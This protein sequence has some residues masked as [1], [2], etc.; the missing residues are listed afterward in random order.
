M[1]TAAEYDVK[2]SSLQAVCQTTI[3]AEGLLSRKL[4]RTFTIV[5]D[6]YLGLSP[7]QVETECQAQG[8]L[9]S[10]SAAHPL[11]PYL[12]V[13]TVKTDRKSPLFYE[14]EVDYEL[15]GYDEEGGGPLSAPAVINFFTLTTQ[16]GIDIDADG[17]PIATK[18]LSG[19]VGQEEEAWLEPI[20]GVTRP[21]SDLAVRIKQGIAAFN[22]IAF[23]A[24]ENH[25][26]SDT[27]LGFPPGTA[28]IH[29][30][31]A[32][33]RKPGSEFY[34][35]LAVEIHFR[36]PFWDTPTEKAWYT[37]VLCQ[38]HKYWNPLAGGGSN[39]K[40]ERALTDPFDEDSPWSTT[41]VFL[42]KDTGQRLPDG[43]PAQWNLFRVFEEVA[44][45]TMELRV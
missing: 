24:Y 32:D 27:F 14:T 25:V 29:S 41:P 39:G 26:N 5:V 16:S 9:P 40:I 11:N 3:D 36:K 42:D 45:S 43:A 10:T 4:K 6:G 28:R 23:Y 38:G 7:L 30:I 12:L 17:K 1:P 21:L 44:Y 19:E 22:P 35:D 2:E 33:P 34:W 18:Y 8:L 37:R 13:K 15:Y 20:T 31:T